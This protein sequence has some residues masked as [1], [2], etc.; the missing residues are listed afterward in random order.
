M[1]TFFVISLVKVEEEGY[2]PEYRLQVQDCATPTELVET[3]RASRKSENPPIE[4]ICIQGNVLP[5]KT[6]GSTIE[7]AKNEYSLSLD[8][9]AEYTTCPVYLGEK[10]EKDA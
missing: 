10:G 5:M 4:L 2:E 1:A 6:D 9:V 3:L 7:I 8:P